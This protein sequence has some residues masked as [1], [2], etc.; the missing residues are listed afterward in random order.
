MDFSITIL[1]ISLFLSLFAV[2]CLRTYTFW[3]RFGIPYIKPLPL[4]GTL[5]DVLTFKKNV[6]LHFYDIYKNPAFAKEPVVGI[7]MLHQPALLIRDPEL[8]KSMLIKNFHNFH[9]RYA[10]VDGK[11]DHFGA[12]NLFVSKYETWSKMRP[13][14][15]P[16]FSSGKLKQI[17]PSMLEVRL[18]LLKV[19]RFSFFN[20]KKKVF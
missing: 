19:I 20:M 6:G 10:N 13:K 12:L 18:L 4:I 9:D 7:Y 1:L 17:F 5:K 11:I 2:W 15:S 14:F 16:T 8:I 3:Q